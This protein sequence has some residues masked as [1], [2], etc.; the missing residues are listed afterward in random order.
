VK[1][2]GFYFL[3]LFVRRKVWPGRT[4]LP[5]LIIDNWLLSERPAFTCCVGWVSIANSSIERLFDEPKVCG[6]GTALGE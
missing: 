2:L 5:G 4:D 1:S 3:G 6:E